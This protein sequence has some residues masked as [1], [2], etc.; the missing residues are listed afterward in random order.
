MKRQSAKRTAISQKG[1]VLLT[2]SEWL[3]SSLLPSLWFRKKEN[4]FQDMGDWLET[5]VHTQN[6]TQTLLM[7]WRN[8]SVA[9]L[10]KKLTT[11]TLPPPNT[12]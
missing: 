4:P 11:T 2:A 6:T 1:P 5:S 10:S 7:I 3:D 12:Q 8:S 9:C